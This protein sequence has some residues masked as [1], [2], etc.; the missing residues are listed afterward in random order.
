MAIQT[1]RPSLVHDG[2]DSTSH[3]IY[4]LGKITRLYLLIHSHERRFYHF[5]KSASSYKKMEFSLLSLTLNLFSAK[6]ATW[7]SVVIWM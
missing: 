2:L 7:L 6:M 4:S 5:L 3:T 1:A